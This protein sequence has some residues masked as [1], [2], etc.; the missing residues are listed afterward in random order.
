MFMNSYVDFNDTVT[1]VIYTDGHPISLHDC[2]PI[3]CGNRVVELVVPRTDH[4][5]HAERLVQQ[6]RL[7]A[8]QGDRCRDLLRR[9]HALRVAFEPVDRKS[10]R[11][12]SSH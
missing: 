5:H 12:K 3:Y 4:Q 1:T 6:H 7:L 10:P 8:E 11:L 2:L 9:E